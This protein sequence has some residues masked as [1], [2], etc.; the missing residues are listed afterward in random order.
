MP[1]TE[2]DG[3]NIP[4]PAFQQPERHQDQKVEGQLDSPQNASGEKLSAESSAAL[5]SASQFR[6]L[7]DKNVFKK[8]GET[9]IRSL[10]LFDSQE[11]AIENTKE[12]GKS[13]P[14]NVSTDAQGRV[15]KVIY[16]DEGKT[17]EFGRDASGEI[18]KLTTSTKDGTWTYIKENGQWQMLGEN[19]SKTAA[20][21]FD[22]NKNGEFSRYLE[23]G[24]VQIQ[25]LDGKIT[26]EHI[27]A[28]GGQVRTNSDGQVEKVSRSDGSV[29]TANYQAGKLTS[30]SQIK[31]GVTT[32]FTR[33]I[34]ESN[35]GENAG[36]DAGEDSVWQSNEAEPRSV[37]NLE[38]HKNG[39]LSFNSADGTKH[40]IR[41]SGGEIEEG[42]GKGK[43]QFDDEG[44]VTSIE[45]AD[46]KK[47]R[48]LTYSERNLEPSS[49]K[50]VDT[51]KN[52][53]NTF[54]LT[55]DK[56]GYS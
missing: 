8:S 28:I 52:E 4:S 17:R 19:G 9:Q 10:V 53:T 27:N 45:N 43:Y 30:I 5:S 38:L 44:R 2:I 41:S 56:S 32:T 36:K 34:L 11:K 23:N 37:T 50:I 49:V 33:Q 54:Q 16:A 46:G 39:N 6:E 14:S 18:N 3:A 51:E 1:R 25:A 24:E 47:L 22:I 12:T 13:L 35:A 42:S 31:D 21:G 55:Q 48:T 20:S 40:I 7:Q 26:K 15:N 29:L